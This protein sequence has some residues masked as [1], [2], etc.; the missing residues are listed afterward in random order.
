MEIPLARLAVVIRH[1]GPRRAAEDR[2]PVVGRPVAVTALAVAEQV[3][4]ALRRARRSRQ[5]R[6]EP[7]VLV[8][9]VVGHQVD[10]HPQVE[11]T[12][13]SQQRVGIAQRP[14][15][16]VDVRV[17]L[18]VVAVVLLGREVERRDPERVDAEVAQVG[19][20]GRDAGEVP[21]AVT[22]GVGEAA[23]VD[24][25][26]DGFRPPLHVKSL[27][28]IA[29]QTCSAVATDRTVG[30]GRGSRPCRSCVPRCPGAR[31]RRRAARRRTGRPSSRSE[32]VPSTIG[33][34]S[35]PD[36]QPP[37]QSSAAHVIGTLTSYG[38]QVGGH[39]GS[40]RGEP[41]RED[42]QP[43]ARLAAR[44]AGEAGRERVAP[45]ARGSGSR[46][47][48]P[49]RGMP[50]RR[51]QDPRPTRAALLRP[52]GRRG[53]PRCRRRSGSASSGTS[54]GGGS[55]RATVIGVL[56]SSTARRRPALPPS[57]RRCRSGVGRG[58]GAGR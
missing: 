24:L 20:P 15:E 55:R 5:R 58:S 36:A 29:I 23:D 33:R 17:V 11:L 13:T 30:G 43:V 26:D 2:P 48:R 7:G 16:R 57:S 28:S 4:G 8:G 47:R 32:M 14:E 50:V 37:E 54:R 10:D 52:A 31:R 3:A 44:A 49:R 40:I 39:A 45:R 19:E 22:V 46:R 25:V 41:A 6:L 27:G 9:G 38:V 42:P 18:H 34:S 12:G 56:A 51:G 1:P 53:A 35:I 21:D